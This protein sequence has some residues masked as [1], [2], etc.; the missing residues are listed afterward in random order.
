MAFLLAIKGGTAGPLFAAVLASAA[1]VVLDFVSNW[2]LKKI[3]GAAKKVGA[4]LKGMAEKFKARGKAKAKPGAKPAARPS[5]HH[6]AHDAKPAKHPDKDK[7]SAKDK[8]AQDDKTAKADKTDKHPDKDKTGKDRPA[9]TRPAT[10]TRTRPPRPTRPSRS[11]TSPGGVRD[12]SKLAALIARQPSNSEVQAQL[13]AWKAQHRLTTCAWPITAARSR[14][15]PRSTR[16][17]RRQGDRTAGAGAVQGKAAG[18]GDRQEGGRGEGFVGRARRRVQGAKTPRPAD[19]A[20]HA[21][22]QVRFA[23]V[24]QS[25]T[26]N[27]RSKTK[28]KP[29]TGN[30]LIGSGDG[31]TDTTSFTQLRGTRSSCAGSARRSSCSRT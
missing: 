17:E 11:S 23:G 6:D 26:L 30:V 3:A 19:R 9:R 28:P 8:H 16:G 20:A 15:R 31:K 12:P 29:F 21:E 4:K 10:R 1:V 25:G 7:P 22:D 24:L 18:P 5:D 2:L 13:A 27:G 14:S